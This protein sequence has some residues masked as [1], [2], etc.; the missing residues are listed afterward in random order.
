M[1]GDQYEGEWRE[2]FNVITYRDAAAIANPTYRARGHKVHG[3]FAT[4]GNAQLYGM[5]QDCTHFVIEKVHVRPTI[6]PP[7]LTQHGDREQG[8]IPFTD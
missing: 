6:H 8:T 3:P 2:A 5:E 4:Y 7:F 1:D